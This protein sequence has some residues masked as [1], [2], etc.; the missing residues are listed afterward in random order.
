MYRTIT[1]GDVSTADFHQYLLA[2]VAPRPI[3]FVSTID[4][5][6]IANLAPYSFFNAFSSNPPILVFSSNRRVRNNTT[7]DTLHNVETT[8]EA[9]I[10][11]VSHDIV[12]QAAVAGCEYTADVSEFV[13]AGLTPIPSD[14]VRPFRVAESPVQMECKIREIIS[15]GKHGGAGNLVICEVVKFHV[16]EAVLDER[17]KINQDKIDLMGRMGRIEYVRASGNALLS[18]A[19]PVEPVGLGFD[20]LPS[21]LRNSMVFTGNDLAQ[22]AGKPAFPTKEEIAAVQALPEVA[23][24][25]HDKTA[26]HILAKAYLEKGDAITAFA[27]ALA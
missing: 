16:K 6:G 15:L 21:H 18:I 1:P 23:I 22:F 7:K 25:A 24:V 13:K 12:Y 2:A 20:N 27:I 17:G 14:I 11:M 26:L 4:E 19:Q 5:E 8:R 3:A 9:V 10:N